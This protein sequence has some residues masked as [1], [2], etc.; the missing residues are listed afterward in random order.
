MQQQTQS[1]ARAWP[2]PV[3][4]LAA[5]ALA[6]APTQYS[7]PIGGVY[8]SGVD[9]AMLIAFAAVVASAWK[10]GKRVAVPALALVYLLV[11]A[12]V[13]LGAASGR[14]GGA[15]ILQSVGLFFCGIVV[16]QVVLES[17]RHWAMLAV[18]IGLA[19]NV[20]VALVQILLH[21]CGPAVTGLMRSRMA[22][23][24][25]SAM[26]LCW[27]LP[28]GWQRLQ[29][30]RHG[31]RLAA[32][33]V[34]LVLLVISHGQ[35]LLLAII[36]S[37]TSA[38]LSG[39]RLLTAVGIATLLA[40]LLGLSPAGHEVRRSLWPYVGERLR[41]EHTE[42]VAANRMG[43]ENMFF[44][45]GSGHYQRH[46]GTYYRDLYNPSVNEIET[47]TQSGL[48]I[49]FGSTGIFASLC[50][51]AL[52]GWA[53]LTAW[54]NRREA[55]SQAAAPMLLATLAALLI[56]DPWVRGVAWMPI[57]ALAA[58]S[59]SNASSSA[60]HWRK[61][62][63]H[64]GWRGLSV[65]SGVFTI[66]ALLVAA[67]PEHGSARASR[68][69]TAATVELPQWLL[70]QRFFL[71]ANADDAAQVHAPMRLAADPAG[72]AKPVLWLN[73]GQ[74]PVPANSEP[75]LTH[76]AAEFVFTLGQPLRVNIWLNTWW[77]GTCA[78]SVYVRIN[79]APAVV[80][81]NDGTYDLWH[82]VT[83]PASIDLD[84]GEHRLALINREDGIGIAQ[85]VITDDLRYVP[86]AQEH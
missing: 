11:L 61:G 8:I 20:A 13:N 21:G 62:F 46:I 14:S 17:R 81:G 41:Q 51:L 56:T 83:L 23:G 9:I 53:A 15:E 58:V 27:I 26:A 84:A 6:L 75:A 16:F 31:K 37:M 49:A 72:S 86:Q 63:C 28:F 5:L 33:L 4:A 82:W 34:T 55:L 67:A 43:W 79:D 2:L 24:A 57:L 3:V 85:I 64:L 68:T 19:A 69:S 74:H 35:A 38:W 54:R 77:G 80:A 65:C 36:A 42:L 47:D 12:A 29:S 45:V 40:V 22:F 59:L 60:A 32:G 30:R 70:Q 76:G 39:R 48:G 52:L 66:A 18:S 25:Y 71:V 73:D 7:L 1:S 50:L 78:N 44:G 10:H